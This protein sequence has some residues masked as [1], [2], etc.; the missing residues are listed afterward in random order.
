M[1]YIAKA[2]E[3]ILVLP[4]AFTFN[5]IHILLRFKLYL[6]DC[7]ARN[8]K[9]Q[10]ISKKN[11]QA[12]TSSKK[13]TK[14]T[15]DKRT[16]VWS[17]DFLIWKINFGLWAVAWAGLWNKRVWSLKTPKRPHW[18]VALK[19]GKNIFFWGGRKNFFFRKTI[20]LGLKMPL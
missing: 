8:T 12:L 9:G 10:L 16:D 6:T 1:T 4:R 7:L 19:K 18:K 14:R 13:Q 5:F 20:F 15:Q 11:C 3:M 17:R 2:T